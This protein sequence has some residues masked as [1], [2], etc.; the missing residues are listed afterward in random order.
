MAR[1]VVSNVR[2]LSLT[3]ESNFQVVEDSGQ[4]GSENELDEPVGLQL[5]KSLKRVAPKYYYKRC[6]WHVGHE[7]LPALVY[8]LTP[9]VE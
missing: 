6:H 7:L 3:E 9:T 8:T 2:E 4:P 1:C 5:M